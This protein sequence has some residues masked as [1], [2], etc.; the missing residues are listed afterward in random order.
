M[1]LASLVDRCQFPLELVYTPAKS[2]HLHPVSMHS[3]TKSH[4]PTL[5]P[6]LEIQ[7]LTPQFYTNLLKYNEPKSAF[8]AEAESLPQLSDPISQ[9]LWVSDPALLNE[10]IDSDGP[11]EDIRTCSSFG[12]KSK[13]E[14]TLFM[15]S[16]VESQCPLDQRITYWAA[17]VHFLFTQN[18]AWGFYR[19]AAVELFLLR[20]IIMQMVWKQLWRIHS[21]L[22][23]VKGSEVFL[24]P[25]IFLFLLRAWSWIAGRFYYWW[26]TFP[27]VFYS[28]SPSSLPMRIHGYILS[29]FGRFNALPQLF[30]IS[31]ETFSETSYT[32]S[33]LAHTQFSSRPIALHTATWCG[34][35]GLLPAQSVVL[36]HRSI[37]SIRP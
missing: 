21:H 9:R 6:V 15:S 22:W 1:Y 25:V 23:V 11:S 16:F 20:V 27:T 32:H 10:L 14:S 4:A 12:G 34:E 5:T 28:I 31:D 29:I 7:P 17:R 30:W 33:P 13:I 24:V 2:L 19:L 37:E 26:S 8:A 35:Q 18:T 36:K 3:Q